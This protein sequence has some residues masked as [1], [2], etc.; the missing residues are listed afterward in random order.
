MGLDEGSLKDVRAQR[1]YIFSQSLNQIE[2]QVN[3]SPRLEVDVTR[4][5]GFS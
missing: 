1:T 4:P 2:E 5:A 3:Q